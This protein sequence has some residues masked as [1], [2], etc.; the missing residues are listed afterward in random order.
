MVSVT[1]DD[2]L[3]FKNVCGYLAIKLYGAGYSVSSITLKG[4]KGEKLAG[5]ATVTIQPGETPSVSM[6][7]SATDMVTLVCNTP[8]PL[9][10]GS[11]K[12]TT[13]WFVIPPTGFTEGFTVTITTDGG[14]TFEKSTTK[15]ITVSRNTLIR[16]ASLELA[17]EG[18]FN[19]EY[20]DD[21]NWD[22]SDDFGGSI[23]S[24]G[25]NGDYS[26]DSTVDG[27]AELGKDN[28]GNDS[29][30][31]SNGSDNTT[32]GQ[33]GYGDDTNLDPNENSTGNIEKDGYGDDAN[34]DPNNEGNAD[35][36]KEGYGDDSN[37]DPDGDSSGSIEKD[38]YGEDK[39][40]D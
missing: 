38:G 7:T 1:D 30:W 9:N 18:I 25:Y 17:K 10:A 40:W 34:L 26:W 13:F 20:G 16:M 11:S 3:Q 36:D 39:N 28:Y 21:S 29:D 8:V 5:D 15:S 37:W 33:E 14:E 23:N 12:Y 32:I 24:N 31:D 35:I 22:H 4:N 19:H 6:A 2:H 27:N